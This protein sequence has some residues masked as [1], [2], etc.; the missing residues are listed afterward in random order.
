MLKTRL[1]SHLKEKFKL[2]ETGGLLQTLEHSG[3]VHEQP[4]LFSKNSLLNT[5][6]FNH[7]RGRLLEHYILQIFGA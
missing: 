5:F 2:E 3:C 4:K 6:I 7:L 1:G